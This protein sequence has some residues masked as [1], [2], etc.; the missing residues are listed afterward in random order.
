MMS[1]EKG[2][3]YVA[4][5]DRYFA[6]VRQS[7]LSV[8]RHMPGIPIL[9]YTDKPEAFGAPFDEIR[10][11][12]APRYFFVD[13]VQPLKDAP[14]EK[15]LFLDTDTFVCGDVSDLFD[16]L[17][18]FDLALAHA[19]MRHDRPY[20]TPN[21]FAEM[22]S[23]VLAYRKNERVLD[24]FERWIT[25]YDEEM[26]SS[27]QPER[28]DQVHL[29]RAVYESEVRPYILPPEYNYRSVVMGWAARQ[30]VRIIHGRSEDMEKLARQINGTTSIRV[31]F[32]GLD[33]FTSQHVVFLDATGGAFMKAANLFVGMLV[34]LKRLFGK[35]R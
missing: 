35:S 11:I 14:F 12:E 5:G 25:I 23:G 16:L 20:P 33:Q 18:R 32:P 29:R 26:R 6:E 13:K 21:C 3:L 31:T 30:K 15:T 2:V 9:L 28:G 22:N 27:T 4:T 19:P 1:S 34:R 8:K 17:D 24:M 10:K 7:A